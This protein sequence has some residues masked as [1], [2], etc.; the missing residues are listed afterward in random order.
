MHFQIPLVI[1]YYSLF[2]KHHVLGV[3]RDIGGLFLVSL[4]VQCVVPSVSAPPATVVSDH[5]GYRI[6]SPALKSDE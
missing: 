1:M 3:C 5:H 6:G 2:E 4:A